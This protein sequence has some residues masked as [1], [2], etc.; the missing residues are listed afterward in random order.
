MTEFTL[1]QLKELETIDKMREI[2]IVMQ[3]EFKK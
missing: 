2:I 1:S 3:E